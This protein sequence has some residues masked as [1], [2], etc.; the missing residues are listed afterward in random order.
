MEKENKNVLT[1]NQ[2]AIDQRSGGAYYDDEI[3][4]VDLWLVLVKRKKLLFFIMGLFIVGGLILA[5]VL[6]KQYSYS[7]SIEIGSRIIK[8]NVQPIESPETL[9]AKIQESY[10]PLVQHQYRKENPT[11]LGKYGIKARIPKGSQIIVLGSKGSE[12]NSSIY[13]ALQQRVVDEVKNDHKRI[14]EIIR[15][16]MEIARNEAL[17]K[18]EEIK[19]ISKLLLARESRLTSVAELLK[20][21]IEDAKKDLAIAE[22]NRQRSIKEATNEA[23]A[24]TLLMLDNEVQQQRERLATLEERLI[25]EIAEGQ[26]KLAKE[27]SD[28]IRTQQNQKDKIARVEAQLANLVETRALVPPMQ[29][30]EP[31]GLSKRLILAIAIILGIVLGVFVVFF[32]EFIQK[33]NKQMQEEQQIKSQES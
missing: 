32:A 20:N 8:D 13:T 28:N 10:I 29:S 25:T 4:L 22:K 12:K 14:L 5:F 3:S 24:M 23:K 21:Q 17:S 27:I 15:K 33:A 31:T 18:L 6:P 7:T 2:P 11:D 1:S 26:D 16:E 30:N 9:L 19:D